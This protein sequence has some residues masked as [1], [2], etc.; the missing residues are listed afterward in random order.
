MESDMRML[1]ALFFKIFIPVFIH[2]KYVLCKTQEN[3]L[4]YLCDVINTL[5][6]Y[7]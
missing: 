1:P 3:G 7:M 2:L 6:I 5:Q 4:I